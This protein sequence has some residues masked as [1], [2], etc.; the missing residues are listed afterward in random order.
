MNLHLKNVQTQVLGEIGETNN[1]TFFL[2]K[3]EEKFKLNK[4]F[5]ESLSEQTSLLVNMKKKSS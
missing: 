2:K 5:K 1:V 4:V 3:K